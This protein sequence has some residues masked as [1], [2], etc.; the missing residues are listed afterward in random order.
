VKRLLFTC[1]ALLTFFGLSAQENLVLNPDFELTTKEKSGIYEI[2]ADKNPVRYWYGTGK[3]EAYLFR[4][5]KEYV[6]MASS[7]QNAIG[8]ILGRSG[9]RSETSYL[10][11]RLK[12][13]LR[14]GQTYCICYDMLLHRTSRLA[15]S[16]VGV[17]LHHDPKLLSAIADPSSINATLYANKGQPVTNTKWQRYCG[18]Y[19]ASGGEKYLSF[20]KFGETS[21]V[22]VDEWGKP[23]FP[24]NDDYQKLAFYQLDSISVRAIENESQCSCAE[25]LPEIPDTSAEFPPYLFAL[26]ASG[27]MTRKGLFDSLRV[28]LVGFVDQLPDGSPVSFSTFANSTSQI[29]A[30][31]KE[32][33]TSRLVNDKLLSSDV[34]GSTNALLG[35]EAAYE[36]W[37]AEEPDSA[38]LVFISDGEFRVTEKMI[39]LVKDQYDRYGRKIILIQIGSEATGLLQLRSYLQAYIHITP[40]EINQVISSLLLENG[41]S[42]GTRSCQC[43][44]KYPP[45][46]NF[47]FIIDY[48]YSMVEENAASI[49]A[50]RYLFDNVPDSALIS[51]TLFNNNSIPLYLG[52]K[53]NT[54]V[55]AML[56]MLAEE[57]V[58]GGTVIPAGVN[59]ALRVVREN[60]HDRF[61]ALILI[62]DYA[63][64]ELAL[65]KY[66]GDSITK[67]AENAELSLSVVHFFMDDAMQSATSQFDMITKTFYTVSKKPFEEDLFARDLEKC[68]YRSQP[69]YSGKRMGAVKVFIQEVQRDYIQNASDWE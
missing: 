34:G 17:I 67:A 25:R 44:E 10:T 66:L 20:G 18:Y 41:Q 29:F 68:D 3:S 9:F 55:D 42:I 1:F 43:L 51:L 33:N 45:I 65:L 6:A 30:G 48:S 21:P 53:A 61:N 2:S 8:L 15:A 64:A 16:E 31:R 56:K 37:P 7:G 58:Y 39:D 23:A 46:S 69:H 63:T 57:E 47:H 13:P 19:L 26:D 27:S 22:K 50:F 32:S 40:P 35:L 54:S 5:P 62:T 24:L 4:A 28:S 38:R 59:S 60:S 36:S 11:G 12:D 14:K 49:R 52:N